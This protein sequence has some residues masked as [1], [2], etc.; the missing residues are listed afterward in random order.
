GLRLMLEPLNLTYVIKDEA[1][2]ITTK[3]KASTELTT[4]I[5]DV[6]DLV[7]PEG[8]GD[9]DFDSLIGVLTESV[10]I[11][12]WSD[13]G[14]QG[15]CQAG[16]LGTLVVSQT[17]EIQPQVSELLAALRLAKAQSKAGVFDHAITA[18]ATP[19]NQ[20]IETLL[21]DKIDI[22]ADAISLND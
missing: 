12:S 6:R 3:D 21:A 20:R 19:A 13:K 11:E 15:S 14:G 9:R 1:L 18:G 17:E 22:S 2:Q 8:G 7:T 5:Y 16:P 4:G 10:A